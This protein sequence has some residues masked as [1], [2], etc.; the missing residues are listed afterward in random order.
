MIEIQ[1]AQFGTVPNHPDC[2]WFHSD[3]DIDEIVCCLQQLY[4]QLMGW[5]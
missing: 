4:A 5:A 1:E 2:D 3:G